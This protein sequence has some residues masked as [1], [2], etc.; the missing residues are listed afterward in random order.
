MFVG[1][2]GSG[3][4]TTCSKVT[5]SE[6]VWM[7]VVFVSFFVR[8]QVVIIELLW[9]DFLVTCAVSVSRKVLTDY[10]VEVFLQR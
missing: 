9:W 7:C 1:L 8:G 6:S 2:Q 4:T 10:N 3:K 5:C